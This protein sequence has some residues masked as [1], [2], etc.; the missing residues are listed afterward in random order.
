MAGEG[1]GAEKVLEPGEGP[2]SPR[3][4]SGKAILGVSGKSEPWED[5]STVLL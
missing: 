3:I 4:G 5:L 1:S 2:G